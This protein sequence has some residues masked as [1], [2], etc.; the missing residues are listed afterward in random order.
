MTVQLAC[1]LFTSS[2]FASKLLTDSSLSS[3]LIQLVTSS[4]LDEIHPPIRVAAASLAFNIAAYNH[5]RR[6]EE[7]AD[8]LPESGQVELMAS[9]LEAVG[10]EESN[11]GLKGLMLAVGLLAYGA[12]PE[13]E[14][15]EVCRALGAKDVLKKNGLDKELGELAR[16]VASV[17]A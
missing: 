3:S 9:L 2:L 1:N 6:L 17:V 13:G 10:R 8:L 14:L 12:P 5:L 4:L 7:E 11:E 16:E 15:M